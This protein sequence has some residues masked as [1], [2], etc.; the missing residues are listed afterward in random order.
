MSRQK[1]SN[2]EVLDSTPN[3]DQLPD[4]QGDVA[5]VKPPTRDLLSA[6]KRARDFKRE[7]RGVTR[8][9]DISL[10]RTP[11]S[12]IYFRCWPN[13][14]DELPVA[15]LKPK[16]D[17]KSKEVYVLSAEV[18]DL[19][20]VAP[21]VREATLVPCVT[22]TGR[23]YVWA[24]TTPD[25]E[26]KLTFRTFDGLDQICQAARERWV[27]VDWSPGLS[28]GEPPVPMEDEPKWPTGQSLREIFEVAIRNF[29]IDNPDHPVI[30]V[31]NT[32][33]RE[34]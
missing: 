34:V 19:P 23:L 28:M 32:I 9:L 31:L 26:D 12:G 33:K 10:L 7:G 22:S 27:L 29:F 15:I 30:R 20:Y 25:P 5:P 2:V 24:K 13:P 16:T 8:Q 17:T 21:K 14:D 3:G 1:K 6:A 18:A 11:I 4:D